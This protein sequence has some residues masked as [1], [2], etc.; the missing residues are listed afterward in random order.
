MVSN[1]TPHHYG[2]YCK[3]CRRLMDTGKDERLI[4]CGGICLECAALAG[5]PDA[6]ALLTEVNE[7]I[8]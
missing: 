4:D 1:F 6:I 8:T 7:R 2:R 5:D 3:A